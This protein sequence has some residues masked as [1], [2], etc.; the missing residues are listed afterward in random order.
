MKNQLSRISKP[1]YGARFTLMNCQKKGIKLN[2]SQYSVTL[3]YLAERILSYSKK[4]ECQAK[5][6]WPGIEPGLLF[7][8]S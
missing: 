6:S 1:I 2:I 8:V 5:Q 7:R 3:Q 4:W